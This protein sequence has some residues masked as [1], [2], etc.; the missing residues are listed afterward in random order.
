MNYYAK[1]AFK[2]FLL[3][4]F[5]LSST[6]ISADEIKIFIAKD[7]ITLNPNNNYIEAVATQGSKIINVG[8][9]Q[10]LTSGVSKSLKIPL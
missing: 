1:A 5:I 7:I 3:T 2:L 8:S 10:E 9:K 4:V 6:I